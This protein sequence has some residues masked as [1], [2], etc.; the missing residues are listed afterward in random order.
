MG[1][2]VRTAYD[3]LAALEAA[4]A[5]RPDVVL[6]DIGMPGLDGYDAAAASG[7]SRGARTW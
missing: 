2:E 1:H 4:T 7:S 6:L 3:G 5:Y